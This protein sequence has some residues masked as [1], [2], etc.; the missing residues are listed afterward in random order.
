MR[1]CQPNKYIF[2]CRAL[3]RFSWGIARRNSLC[4]LM[5]FAIACDVPDRIAILVELCPLEEGATFAVWGV[6]MVAHPEVPAPILLTLLHN[7]EDGGD[8]TPAFWCVLWVEYGFVISV[9]HVDSSGAGDGMRVDSLRWGDGMLPKLLHLAVHD[10]EGVVRQVDRYLSFIIG[11][12]SQVV[13]G[14]T[15]QYF[16]YAELAGDTEGE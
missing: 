6:A 15:R 13:V 8:T 11:I 5:A 4:N 2:F 16:P 12:L 7:L 14:I 9:G 1:E 10:E 3:Y